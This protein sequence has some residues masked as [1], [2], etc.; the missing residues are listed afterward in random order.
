MILRSDET[1]DLSTPYGPMRTHL[2]RPV[3]EGRYPGVV[4]YSEIFQVTGPIRR[5]AALLAGHGFVV[6]VPEIYHELEPA[7]TVLAYDT[8]GADRG[9]AHKTTK[10]LAS[11]DADARAAL[12]FLKSHPACTGELGVMGI[13]IGGH[14]AFRAAMNPDV[15]AAACFY[16]T[17]IHKRSLAKGMNDDSLVRMGDIQ[18]EMLMIW[19]RQ[20]PHV[21]QEGR[22]LVYQTMTAAG[23]NFTWHEFNAAH[24]FL[25][26]EGPRYD[27]ELALRCYAMVVALFKRKLGPGERPAD[28]PV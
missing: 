22:A 16:A 23:V 26:D 27:P 4:L 25:R 28:A 11:Y 3:A 7:G 12:D 19:G 18:G 8:A 2:F 21:P 14:L 13:C 1:A 20:D 5:T 17:D 15:R 6:A 10:E 24:A 9:N